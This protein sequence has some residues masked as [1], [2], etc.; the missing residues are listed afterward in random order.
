[1][2][3]ESA[4]DEIRQTEVAKQALKTI[5]LNQNVKLEVLVH[6][7]SEDNTIGDQITHDEHKDIVLKNLQKKNL[8]ITSLN[9]LQLADLKGVPAI[10]F[11]LEQCRMGD[12]FPST[13]VCFDLRPRYLQPVKDFTSI[14][15]DVGRAFGY[16]E[17]PT[18]LLSPKAD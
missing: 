4:F 8:N 2:R 12:T 13:C 15:Q 16:G 10:V 1:M 17:R 9:K 3:L 6:S 18:L 14:I 11:I 5:A 7:S